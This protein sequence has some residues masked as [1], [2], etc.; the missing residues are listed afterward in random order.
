MDGWITDLE[1]QKSL[2]T[3]LLTG[4][5]SLQN[6][7]NV[8]SKVTYIYTYTKVEF[9]YPN[10]LFLTMQLKLKEKKKGMYHTITRIQWGLWSSSTELQLGLITAGKL[11]RGSEDDKQRSQLN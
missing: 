7:K 8:F 10:T 2:F 3:F 1:P 9:S 4:L 5:P 6:G 11:S